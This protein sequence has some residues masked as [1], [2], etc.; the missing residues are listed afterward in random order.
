MEGNIPQT[1]KAWQWSSYGLPKDVCFELKNDDLCENQT[2]FPKHDKFIR[3]LEDFP[4]QF[5][6]G[7]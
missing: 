1:M 7:N 3:Q 2:K 5:R 4:F 6:N